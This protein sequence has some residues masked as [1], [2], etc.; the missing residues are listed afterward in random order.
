MALPLEVEDLRNRHGVE[1]WTGVLDANA[2]LGRW[3]G[4]V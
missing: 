4:L 3:S 1:C 2:Y